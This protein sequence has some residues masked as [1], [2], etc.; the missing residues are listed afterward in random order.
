MDKILQVLLFL[1]FILIAV[2]YISN[3]FVSNNPTPTLLGQNNKSSNPTPMPSLETPTPVPSGRQIKVPILLYHYIGGNPNPDDKARDALS[4]SPRNF[5]EQMEFLRKEGFQPITLDTM[6]AALLGQIS[7]PTKPVVISFE[8]GYVDLYHN[9]FP[10]LQKYGFRAVAFIPT[11]L[12]GT[13]YYLSWEQLT[14]IQ[15]S[16]LLSFQSH[17]VSHV[18]LTELS[19][20]RMMLELADSKKQ[21]E[22]RFGIPV[23]FVAYPYGFSN[24]QV[25]QTAQQAGYVGGLGT[26]PSTIQSE[27]T[28]FN[29]PRIKVSGDWDIATFAS[30]L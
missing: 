7:L 1:S 15:K 12:M 22:Q 30:K 23:N 2:L 8:D 25:W 4:V 5:D 27:G 19:K 16:G 9:A 3:N 18:N 10:I 20:E 14:I 29:M 24:T 28:I 26:W 11:R 21:L 13:K 17:S 6:M